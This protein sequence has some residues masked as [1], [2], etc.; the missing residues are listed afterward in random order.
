MGRG[1]NGVVEVECR[2]CKGGFHE[3][4]RVGRLAGT[5]LLVGTLSVG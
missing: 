4:G 2:D 5:L 3:E 1:S